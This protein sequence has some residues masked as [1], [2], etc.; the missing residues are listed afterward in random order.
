MCFF[1]EVFQ[2]RVKIFKNWKEAEQM[3]GKKREAKAKLELAMNTEKIPRATTEIK[4]VGIGQKELPSSGHY[5]DYY[6]G[7]LSALSSHCNWLE[8][9]VPVDEIYG[10][11]IFKWVVGLK[12]T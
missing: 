8:D 2:E 10:Y 12:Q 3:L 9:R 7:A 4:E 5:R 11:P 6:P 1:Q